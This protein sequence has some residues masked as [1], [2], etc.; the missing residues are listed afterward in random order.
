MFNRIL[1][2]PLMARKSFFLFGPRGTGKTSW[3]KQAV[4]DALYFDLLEAKWRILF[5]ANPQR[6][7]EYIAP[8]F[9]G[10]I[11]IDEIQKV[12]DLLNEVHRLIESQG[13]CFILSGSSVRKLY[14]KGVNLLAGRALTYYFH[15]L[16]AQELGAAFNLGHYLQF[17]GLPSVYLEQDPQHYLTSYVA[18][19]LH[20]EVAQEGLTRQLSA[21]ARFLESASFSQGSVLNMSAVARECGVNQKTVSG[22]FDI[23]TE[24][25][26]GYQLMPFTR[27]AKRRVTL[28]AKF[29]FFDVGVYRSLRPQ[30]PMDSTEEIEGMALETL[31]LQHLRAM[32]DYFQLQYSLYYWRTHHGLEVDFI[33]YGSA[34]FLAFEIKRKTKL[35]SNDFQGLKAFL[36]DYPEATAYLIYGGQEK[37]YHGQVKVLPMEDALM[38]LPTLLANKVLKDKTDGLFN[39]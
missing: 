6:L 21:F 28:H 34:G 2:K 27:R 22:Y 20:E 39:Q 30:G 35:A 10:W 3:L 1:K 4:P 14:Q 12:P 17:G 29:Y 13:Y 5:L 33:L 23:L 15:P 8:D 18:T 25:L 31:F 24:L 7:A 38:M 19:Y 32:N 26:M 9:K 11:V 36:E 37:Q 16:L